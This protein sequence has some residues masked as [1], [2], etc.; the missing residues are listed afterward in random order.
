MAR[1]QSRLSEHSN[2]RR[3]GSLLNRR[4]NAPPKTGS[5]FGKIRERAGS[6][7]RKKEEPQSPMKQTSGN[8]LAPPETARV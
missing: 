5:P 3:S 1:M 6:I 8:Y 7:L 4:K 2:R